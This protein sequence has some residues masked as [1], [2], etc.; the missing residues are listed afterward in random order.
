LLAVPN[1]SE[2]RDADRIAA[3]A[4]AAASAPGVRLLDRHSDP[5]HHRT[6]LT[7]AGAPGS[8][9]EAVTRSARAGLE[10]IDLSIHDGAHP[11]VGAIDVAPIV[12]TDAS[13]RGAACAEAL[14]LADRL[15]SELDLPVFLYGALTGGAVTRADVRRGG[16]HALR[17]RIESGELTPDYGPR[18]LHERG[19]AVLVAARP[20]LVAFN[21]ELAM[22]A[23]VRTARWI[24][25][26]IREGGEEGLPTL[27][28]IGL[29]L[30]HRGGVAQV[31]MNLEDHTAVPLA[32]VV[33]AIARHAKPLRAEL[34]GLAPRAAF[35]GFPDQLP[36]RNL[37]FIED[38]VGADVHTV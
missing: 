7:L 6:V 37:R 18:G 30:P 27:R 22:P 32:Q 28:A 24:A 34:V 20:P 4:D 31:S 19:G 15:G 17:A 12:F 26:R 11:R 16:H 14:T 25:A 1:F 8:L 23:D 9:H 29:E 35:D 5:D 3:I 33:A 2:G 10:V 38:G 13:E 36:V 21:V